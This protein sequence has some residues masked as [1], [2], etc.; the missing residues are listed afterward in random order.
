MDRADELLY[1]AMKR[2]FRYMN[3]TKSFGIR[4][5]IGNLNN[6]GPIGFSDSDFNG[7]TFT[8]KSVSSYVSYTQGELYLGGL[9]RKLSLLDPQLKQPI[10]LLLWLHKKQFR[11]VGYFHL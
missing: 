1:R 10:L 7:F 9:K 2:V 6:F 4:Y 3:G 5:L 8:C 11:Q